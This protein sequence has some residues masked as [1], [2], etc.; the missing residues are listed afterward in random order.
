M[1]YL[2]HNFVNDGP[3]RGSV[4]IHLS[5]AAHCA[6]TYWGI[7]RREGC[8]FGLRTVNGVVRACHEKQ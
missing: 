7:R 2:E 8:Y 5:G 6:F 3:K 1:L 4:W